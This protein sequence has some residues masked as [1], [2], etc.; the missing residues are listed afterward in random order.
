VLRTSYPGITRLVIVE[1]YLNKTPAGIIAL[2]TV[3]AYNSALATAT[4][5]RTIEPARR[6]ASRQCW[7]CQSDVNR[8]ASYVAK[9]HRVELVDGRPSK[10]SSVA[11][12]IS[13]VSPTGVVT[14]D[15]D[16][17]EPAIVIRDPSGRIIL[18]NA[19]A[20]VADHEEVDVSRSPA[21]IAIL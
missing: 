1:S 5:D 14:V 16:G 7:V 20:V 11:L 6:L 18:R 9:H 13:S 3:A 15:L 12:F 17:I 2:N 19:S 10:W 21:V 8:I 4:T